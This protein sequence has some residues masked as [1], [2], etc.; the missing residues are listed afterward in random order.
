M[1]VTWTINWT[2]VGWVLAV[3]VFYLIGFYEGQAKGY[4]RRKR[5]EEQEKLSNA[6]NP[7]QT[8]PEIKTEVEAASPIT[9]SPAPI[10]QPLPPPQP[11]PLPPLPTP[12]PVEKPTPKK[13]SVLLRLPA[14]SSN[15]SIRFYKNAS[16]E[17]RWRISA[18]SY[19]NRSKAAW[20][21]MPGKSATTALM[22]RRKGKSKT[23]FARR[24]RNGKRN[25]LPV[26]DLRPVNR[27]VSTG[28]RAASAT[29]AAM[30]GA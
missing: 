29:S 30:F 20:L 12:L 7:I 17:R 9:P 13:R 27:A 8:A 1:H 18:F 28:R 21:F 10:Q 22:K 26:Y 19:R 23:L 11:A 6:P 4:K 24:S 3:L 2:I 16:P 15:R 5:E 25:T 14:V